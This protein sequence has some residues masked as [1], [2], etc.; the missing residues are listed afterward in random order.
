MIQGA[1]IGCG[2]TTYR[3]LEQLSRLCQSLPMEVIDALVIVNDDPDTPLPER[4]G[5]A[6]VI[7]NTQNLGV[8]KSKNKAM[9]WLLQ[10]GVEHVF[11]LEDD[12][13]IKDPEV[14]ARYV[15][16]SALSGIQHFKYGPVAALNTCLCGAGAPSL[17]MGLGKGEGLDFYPAPRG[18]FSYF[19]R[20]CIETVGLY[21]E[22]YYNAFEHIDHTLRIIQHGLHPPFGFFADIADSQ[23]Y[24]GTDTWSEQQSIIG[25]MENHSEATAGADSYFSDKHGLSQGSLL[26]AGLAEVLQAILAIQQRFG[27]VHSVG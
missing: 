20:Y 13:F 25:Q 1:K 26:G 3:R 24:I 22:Q 17:R 8:G 16:A 14:F 9:R 12:V 21:D 2:I 7:H 18:A 5:R 27:R 11:M 6:H 19:S 10:Q 4:L 23:H 15:Q